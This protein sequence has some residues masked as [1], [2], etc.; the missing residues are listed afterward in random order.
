M[1]RGLVGVFVAT[2][3]IILSSSTVGAAPN[4]KL[5]VEVLPINC[6]FDTVVTGDG[7]TTVYIT[8]EE[9]GHPLPVDPEEPS[10][11]NPTETETVVDGNESGEPVIET[12]V[13]LPQTST[14]QSVARTPT[15]GDYIVAPFTQT[16]GN[17]E[18]GVQSVSGSFATEAVTVGASALVVLLLVVV[19]LIFA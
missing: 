18:Y 8:P 15:T 12:I 1:Q 4:P 13:T 16:N 9:C 7:I 3:G 19:I 14:R 11:E 6:V 17:Y 10:P 2:V 5:R